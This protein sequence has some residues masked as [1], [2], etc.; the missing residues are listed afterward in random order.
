MEI[1]H[2]VIEPLLEK[3]EQYGKTSYELFRLKSIHKLAEV[4]SSLI[5]KFYLVIALSCCSFLF[6]IA[7]ALWIGKWLGENYYGF[8]ITATCYG[9]F[10]MILFLCRARIKTNANDSIIKQ[11]LN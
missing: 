7:A 2:S 11:I 4:A 6:S 9:L 8:L 10:A 3:V 5:P 1:E